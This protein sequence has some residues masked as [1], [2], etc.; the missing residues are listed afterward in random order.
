[1]EIINLISQSLGILAMLIW[2][3]KSPNIWALVL[4]PIVSTTTAS[5]LYYL[6]F[7]YR[8]EFA[9]NKSVVSEVISFGKWIVIS[10]F[11][12]F[13]CMQGDRFFFASYLSA[14]ELGVYSIAFFLANT[15]TTVIQQLSSKIWF[16]AFSQVVRHN[17]KALLKTYYKIR[18]VQDAACFFGAGFLF[19]T[20]RWIISFLYDSRYQE[21]GWMLQILSF[22][23]I[24][25]SILMLGQECLSALGNSKIR[26]IIMVFRCIGLI[27]GLPMSFKYFGIHGA[28]WTVAINCWLG[29]P[30]L[31]L[32]LYK[33]GLF[34]IIKELRMFPLAA[35]GFLMGKSLIEIL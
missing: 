19:A 22:S 31:Y 5:I 34:S 10:S 9:W 27:I 15:I 17:S 8:H 4:A 14:S 6:L 21:A 12:S 29:M 1:M 2:A 28:V 13:L 35:I 24:G 32:A 16:T 30:A 33:E 3:W 18:L 26:M 25:T 23:I 11:L 20:G 7:P